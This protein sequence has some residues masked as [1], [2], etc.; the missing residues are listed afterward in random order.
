MK[1]HFEKLKL[2]INALPLDAWF[3]A[4]V[5]L[6]VLFLVL[7]NLFAMRP[8]GFGDFMLTNAGLLLIAPVLVLQNV[9]TEVWGKKTALK[10]TL[11]AISCQIFIVLLSELI[12]IL[13]TNNPAAADNFA[14]IFGSQWRIVSASIIAFAIGSLLNILVFAKIRE[15]S[16]NKQGNYKWLYLV[17]AFI[18]TVVAQFID[19]TIF[20]VLA[21]AQIGLVN[22]FE[23][24]WVNIW[25]SIG[26]GTTLQLLLETTLV[27][28]IAAHLAKFLKKKK[29]E[30]TANADARGI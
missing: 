26:V 17:A 1:K 21:F 19:S 7:M 9:I 11:F 20:N 13:P 18:S 16:Q 15:K 10:V 3:T 6:S 25:T 23:L 30:S 4:F 22:T 24:P 29:E 5:A 14:S 12:I 8:I 28:A 2:N 27:V